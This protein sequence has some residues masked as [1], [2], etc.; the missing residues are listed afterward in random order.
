MGLN[1]DI[2]EILGQATIRDVYQAVS[3]VRTELGEKIDKLSDVVN[4]VVT[5]HEHRLT[6]VE[7]SQT[8]HDARI[9]VNEAEMKKHSDEIAAVRDKLREDEAAT[10]ALADAASKRGAARRWIV[11]TGIAVA[12][13]I[14]T[15]C[16]IL[17]ALH[18]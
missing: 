15:V 1:D 6:V 11:G 12:G 13:L 18:G 4:T 7:Q 14:A 3:D 10:A 8:I 9:T 2:S 16:Y 5:S 17:V